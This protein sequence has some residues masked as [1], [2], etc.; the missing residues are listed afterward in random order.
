MKNATLYVSLEP[1]CHYGRTGPCTEKIIKS[2]IGSVVVGCNDVNPVVSGSGIRRLRKAGIKVKVGILKEEAEKINKPFFFFVKNKRPFVTLKLAASLDG[3]IATR[4]KESKWIT[5]EKARA[6]VQ[7]LRKASD[8]LLVGARTVEIDD[9]RLNI[10][11]IDERSYSNLL[12]VIVDGDLITKPDRRVFKTKG[13]IL[14]ATSNQAIV[15]KQG[16]RRAQAFRSCGATVIPFPAKMVNEGSGSKISYKID[17]KKL[18]YEL[19]RMGVVNLLV[20]GG[21]G[22]AGSLLDSGLIDKV[23]FF[24]APKM[25]GGKDATPMIGGFGIKKLKDA[26]KIK[27]LTV[28]NIGEDFLVEGYVYRAN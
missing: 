1:C 22:V 13:R 21:G 18:L 28:R 14:I 7:K 10:R 27:D 15:T 4:T 12:R 26:L 3:K 5:G 17:L 20:E 23:V 2:G 24:F 25:I 16:K 6:L 19:G 9:P 11:A 8:A